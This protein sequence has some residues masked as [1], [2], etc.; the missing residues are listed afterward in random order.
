MHGCGWMPG[1]VDSNDQHHS[2]SF[3]YDV[4]MQFLACGEYN[5][6]L[7]KQGA[8]IILKVTSFP[9]VRIA[10]CSNCMMQRPL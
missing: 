3:T 1:I 2:P 9:F 4:C 7:D 8:L 6:V 10:I 5:K